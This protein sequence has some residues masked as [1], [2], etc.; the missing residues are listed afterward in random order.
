MQ[1]T[2]PNDLNCNRRFDI[3][4]GMLY[5]SILVVTLFSLP[6]LLY[7]QGQGQ[8]SKSES[9]PLK[10]ASLEDY[11]KHAM[12]RDGNPVAGEKLFSAKK[13]QCT[14][15]HTTDGSGRM[16]GP[17][18]AAAGD[19]FSRADL[20]QSILEPSANIMTGY[21]LS[22]IKTKDNE[23]F[24]GI[25]KHSSA[26]QLVIAGPG[27]IRHRLAKSDIKDH[28]TSP[29]SMMPSNLYATLS[30]DEFS[31][32]IAYLENL[33][34]K[35]STERNTQGTPA[36]IERLAAPIKLTPLFGQSLGLEKPVWFGE[37]PSIDNMFV[38]M[39]KSRARISILE[40]DDDG[41]EIRSTFL[42]IPEEVYVTNDEGLLGLAFHPNFS[43]NRRYYFMHEIKDGPRR[44][45]MIGERI[46][47]ENLLKDSGN[48]TRQV[49]E[50]EVATQF[51][52]GGGLEF[53]P[54]G[55]LYIGVGDGGPQ[56]DPHGHAQDLSDYSGK[57]LRIDVDDQKGGKSYGIPRDN[58]F[59]NHKNHEVL[60]EIFAYG[61]RQPW[62][63]SFD[64]ANGELWVGDVGQ[65]RFEE[66]AIVRA[67]ENHGWNVYEGFELFSTRYRKEKNEYTPPVVS[68]R[69]KHGVSITGGYV[70]RT[71]TDKPSSFDGVYICADYQ[72]RR[73]WGIRHE[74]RKLKTI[75]EIGTCPD[76]LVSFGQDRSGNIYAVGYNQGIIY[77]L[78]F[79][80]AVFK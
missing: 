62:R 45:M 11:R 70:I 21:S 48:P 72:S 19:K 34:D 46:A 35:S 67:G 42:E 44:G 28:S 14:L 36:E 54:D 18:L 23:V 57:L 50:F 20:I 71:E 74:N 15:C 33:K 9:P 12:S 52:H 24:S 51:H 63:F 29:V 61:L 80:G 41:R 22:V 13:T 73:I 47:N 40:K 5:S 27:D 2:L 58:P 49:L 53:G 55:F 77:R 3:L 69:R 10:V 75:R 32:L 7:C 25:I 78:D 65:N 60:P 43:E 56:E 4:F 6:A 59:I 1:S 68:F 31:N 66:I 38:V 8:E 30:K 16:A 39:E 76:R 79:E 64:P 26:K 17:D 37:H